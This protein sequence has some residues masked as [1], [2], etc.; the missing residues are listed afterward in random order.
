MPV[1]V[2]HPH[3][4]GVPPAGRVAYCH[5]V[6]AVYGVEFGVVG[7]ASDDRRRKSKLVPEISKYD[8]LLRE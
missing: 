1:V 6:V 4:D 2:E 8:G 3:V 7:W 5:D